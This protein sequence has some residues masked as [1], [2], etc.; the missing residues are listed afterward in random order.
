MVLL[1]LMCAL[2]KEGRVV[3][4]DID[5]NKLVGHLK[6]A[7]KKENSVTIQGPALELQLFLAKGTDGKWLS[8][9]SEPV[10][11]LKKGEK[12]AHIQALM[13]E[14][15]ELQSEDVLEDV[16]YGMNSPSPCQIHILVK[17]TEP[18]V[19]AALLTAKVQLP[20]A[21]WVDA[22]RREKSFGEMEDKKI[23]SLLMDGWFRESF[24]LANKKSIMVGSS[25]IGKSTLLCMMAFHLVFKHKKNVLVYRQLRKEVL[26]N[27]LIYLGY[28]DGK[29]VQ[30][31]LE[32]CKDQN[33]IRHI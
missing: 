25:G 6:E 24:R 21:T 27:C 17:L 11:K 32:R 16:L 7:I 26:E 28:E 20:T 23:V 4:V 33:A 5:S 15:E 2:V 3:L 31:A 9:H 12:T 22:P 18:I 1:S 13:E 14:D 8:S 30:F 29:V 10:K 19:Y